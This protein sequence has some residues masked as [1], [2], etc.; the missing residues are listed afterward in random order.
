MRRRDLFVLTTYS[1]RDNETVGAVY[2]WSDASR[3]YDHNRTGVARYFEPVIRTRSGP[4]AQNM[5]HIQDFGGGH[6]QTVELVCANRPL[7]PS[8]KYLIEQL[9][10]GTIFR[11]TIEVVEVMLRGD[12]DDSDLTNLPGDEHVVVFRGELNGPVKIATDTFTLQFIVPEPKVP[13]IYAAG[14]TVDIDDVGKR[15]PVV[16]GRM[17]RV[18][19]VGLDVGGESTLS[20]ALDATSPGADVFVSTIER[21]QTSGVVYVDGERITF[22]G[23]NTTLGKLTG[24]NR[25]SPKAHTAG[26]R[27]L[28]IRDS[29]F[30]AAGH[31]VAAIN[32]V[33][34]RRSSG[35]IIK[36]TTDHTK[37][38]NDT[39][40]LPGETTATIKLSASQ[41]EALV[42]LLETD[43]PADVTQQPSVSQQSTLT[44]LGINSFGDTENGADFPKIG[45]FDILSSSQF[46]DGALGLPTPC[47]ATVVWTL[48]PTIA[49]V[50][51]AG[52]FPSNITV[53]DYALGHTDLSP[54]SDGDFY[55][56]VGKGAGPGDR[57]TTAERDAGGGTNVVIV[58]PFSFSNGVPV[59]FAE[60][61]DVSGLTP[62]ALTK[63]HI[64]AGS[65]GTHLA[66]V[67]SIVAEGITESVVTTD[68][69][70]AG[71]DGTQA[72]VNEQNRNGAARL[73]LYAGVDGFIQ[74]GPSTPFE[75]A[76]EIMEH[77]ITVFCG[78]TNAGD[79][80]ADA[81]YAVAS[82]ND[83]GTRKHTMDVR[84]LGTGFAQIISRFAW[85]ARSNIVRLEG[86]VTP[87]GSV[88]SLY[89]LEFN[90]NEFMTSTDGHEPPAPVGITN[91]WTISVLAYLSESNASLV[92][93]D[94][95]DFSW[96]GI[97]LSELGGVIRARVFDADGTSLKNYTWV[98][99]LLG[100]DVVELTLFSLVWDGTN[101]RLFADGA[102]L[103]PTIVTDDAITMTATDR[104]ITTGAMTHGW[105]FGGAI[106]GAAIT[107][108]DELAAIAVLMKANG[109]DLLTDSGDYVSS[110]NL[111][112]WFRPGLSGDTAKA[113][114][115]DPT[116]EGRLTSSN[117][118]GVSAI[119]D[120]D[121][122]ESV[123]LRAFFDGDLTAVAASVSAL[124]EWGNAADLSDAATINNAFLTGGVPADF[125][126]TVVDDAIDTGNA[127]VRLFYD[128]AAVGAKRYLRWTI[129]ETGL[130]G[131]EAIG[132]GADVLYVPV[133]GRPG[134]TFLRDEVAANAGG[135]DIGQSGGNIPP[136][137]TAADLALAPDT[138]PAVPG[139][140]YYRMRP[141]STAANRFK[142]GFPY[143]TA[144]DEDQ[145][146]ITLDQY[147][148]VA[149]V[150]RDPET[151]KTR[152]RALYGWDASRGGPTD[153]NAFRYAV[154]AGPVNNSLAYPSAANFI[155]AEKKYGRRD[156]D[157]LIFLTMQAPEP[158][159]DTLAFVA[160][161]AIL[162]TRTWEFGS[163]PWEITYNLEPGDSI[164]V[165]GVPW[166]PA[167]PWLARVLGI[168]RNNDTGHAGVTAIGL[169]RRYA[170]EGNGLILVTGVGAVFPVAKFT[171]AGAILP[172]I[173][174]AGVMIARV[175]MVGAGALGGFISG[176]GVV[177]AN[178]RAGGNG[179]IG[180][181]QLAGEGAVNFTL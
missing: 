127:N 58:G 89:A 147:A 135:I 34:V 112:H 107:D 155:A 76:P 173:S 113:I 124:L 37:N 85:E 82:L 71:T 142:Y 158:A 164:V 134:D 133:D 50:F 123:R 149:E 130:G 180:P 69:Q 116:G 86:Q 75:T 70:V 6:A 28:E 11:A 151:I 26:A 16:Y 77:F 30:A 144:L 55:I 83:A 31:R 79:Q 1:D 106:W 176:T 119:M 56:G 63:V 41:F 25:V 47:P 166:A 108:A 48:S 57:V 97:Y 159:I 35:D 170:Y 36:L 66:S 87:H 13:W 9:R 131:G 32:D 60:E 90:P 103:S 12:Q 67:L 80:S 174:G 115:L 146:G 152:F 24:T 10:E 74:T 95:L 17:P 39:T 177:I 128:P 5:S 109:G 168:A 120:T 141:A 23:R 181:P 51:T 126:F 27:V 19:C 98:G 101:L 163:V 171:G 14:P 132:I 40:T 153:P 143:M 4:D 15:L 91:A 22:S 78:L 72:K 172:F 46:Q 129:T 136:W 94:D 88:S 99:A 148:S 8:G 54:I 165:P 145:Q 140:T 150:G 114:T 175:T 42:Q 20:A 33:Y 7:D 137:I 138:T 100:P 38:A 92:Q 162:D 167:D 121:G 62:A 96:N 45:W 154:Q 125:D 64:I 49:S 102:E 53:G 21:F 81:S 169:A 2:Y 3:K 160:H 61:L 178:V 44:L 59:Q 68:I 18:E 93:I 161:T 157:T 105:Y 122:L 84:T 118:A 29:V 104:Y 117:T 43:Q 110:A 156:E 73:K 52:F 179:T 139:S 65:A 111:A